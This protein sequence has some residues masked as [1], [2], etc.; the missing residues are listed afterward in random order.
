MVRIIVYLLFL[1]TD[2]DASDDFIVLLESLYD[3]FLFWDSCSTIWLLEPEIGGNFI[4]PAEDGPPRY[5]LW[6]NAAFDEVAKGQ[7]FFFPLFLLLFDLLTFSVNILGSMWDEDLGVLVVLCWDDESDW[8]EGLF[9]WRFV[10]SPL[11]ITSVSQEEEIRRLSAWWREDDD[12]CEYQ[13][14][15]KG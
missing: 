15:K 12:R 3:L 8:F 2:Q 13:K 14:W 11:L 1:P 6:V 4:P 10:R 5:E 9:E 7:A